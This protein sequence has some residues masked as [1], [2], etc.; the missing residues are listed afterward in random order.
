MTRL[1]VDNRGMI[2]FPQFSLGFADAAEKR[3]DRERVILIH[4]LARSTRSLAAL[5]LALRTYG[6]RVTH[7]AYPSTRASPEVLLREIE[8]AYARPFAGVTH[9]VTHSM[10]SILVRDWLAHNRP[11][12]LGRVVMLAPPNHGSELV[13]ALGD[14]PVFH[15][16]N[17]AAGAS[18][19]TGPLSWPKALP[20]A[21]YALGIIAGTRSLNPVFSALLPGA[22]DGK[23]TVQS[24]RLAGMSDH[25]ALAVTHTFMMRNPVVIRQTLRFLAEGRFDP[26]LTFLAAVKEALSG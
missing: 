8:A 22:N 24:T 17:G 11:A 3:A 12:T 19:G 20:P 5:G 16:V 6:Y 7:A 13:D 14:N 23:V 25:I 9:F 1:P 21:D 10:G 2:R 26:G 18:L 4:G 15:W